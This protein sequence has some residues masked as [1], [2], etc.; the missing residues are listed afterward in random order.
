MKKKPKP[1][2]PIFS[3]QKTQGLSLCKQTIIGTVAIMTL[4]L[5]TVSDSRLAKMTA[6]IT[7]IV[8]EN[9]FPVCQQYALITLQS[10][11]YPCHECEGG[12][13]FLNFGEVWRYGFAGMGGQ[14]SR[15]PNGVFYKEGKWL[16]DKRHLDYQVQLEGTKPECEIEEKL[17]IYAYPTLPEAQKRTIKLIRPPGNKQDR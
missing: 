8:I 7:K 13:I 3:S 12:Q 15:Y 17:K 11:Y 16:L 5:A 9:K 4:G 2:L 10:T 14:N 6:E 1:K